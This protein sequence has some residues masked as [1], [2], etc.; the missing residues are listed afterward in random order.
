MYHLQTRWYDPTIGRFISPDSYEYLDPETFGG[1]N[2]YAYCLNNP[3]MYVDPSGHLPEWTKWLIGG[4]GQNSKLIT[5]YYT[6][7]LTKTAMALL[8][9]I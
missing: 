2:L 6:K 3:I 5:T 8:G 1:L 4:V 9:L 7:T